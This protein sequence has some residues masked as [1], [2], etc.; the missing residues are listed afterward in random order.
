MYK[1]HAVYVWCKSAG[2]IC[3]PES[4]TMLL[5]LHSKLCLQSYRNRYCNALFIF[6]SYVSHCTTEWN[7]VKTKDLCYRIPTQSNWLDIVK[8][9]I[10]F[11]KL[12]HLQW[13]EIFKILS[14]NILPFHNGLLTYVWQLLFESLYFRYRI[15][16]M[17]WNCFPHCFIETRVEP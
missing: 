12:H 15:L 17:E 5:T 3:F 2:E 8:L 9:T 16:V 7:F 1:V 14:G 11:E 10:D 6:N 4:S 13:F